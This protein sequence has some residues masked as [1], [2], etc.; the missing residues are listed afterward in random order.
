MGKARIKFVTWL[1]DQLGKPVLWSQKGPGSFDCS[2]LV[3]AAL[4]AIGGAGAPDLRATHNS[5]RLADETPHLSTFS[6]IAVPMQGDLCFYGLDLGGV[7]HVA[8]WL[9]SGKAI[10]ADG[11]TPKINTLEESQKNPLNR[12]R[13]HSTWKFRGDL[14][15]SAIHRNTWLD[16]L[17]GVCR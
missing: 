7:E 9:D 5:Q 4:H 11:A 14:P 2:G 8:I 10:S 1:I 15:Y 16:A 3:T 12:V 17:E 6:D 13:L